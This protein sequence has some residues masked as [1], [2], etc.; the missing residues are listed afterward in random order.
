MLKK[1]MARHGAL[2]LGAGLLGASALAVGFASPALAAQSGGGSAPS[3][4]YNIYQGG[5]NTTY[6]MMQQLADVFNQAPGCDLASLTNTA[7][8]LDYGCPG[9]ND[10]GTT[11]S[12]PQSTTVTGTVTSG[13]KT[14]TAV[15]S[16]TGFVA[17]EGVS[18]AAGDIPA[19]TKIK[20]VT[21][22][23]IKISKPATGSA[24]GEN[25]SV[26][27]TPAVG[28]DG[29]TTFAQENPFNDLLIEEPAIG[30]SNGIQELEDQNAHAAG[31]SSHGSPIN[32]APLDVA[33]SSRAPNL[34]SPSSA[35]DDKGLN[36]V[37]Y[38]MDAVTWLHWTSVGNVATPSAA[39]SN[40][41]VANLT[42]IYMNQ[43]CTAGGQTFTT[44]NW[45]CFGGSVAPISVYMAQNGSG[46]ESTWASLLGLTG[47]FPFGGEDPN[48]VIFENETSSILANKDQANAIFFFSFG[49][50]E[51]IC[52]SNPTFCS[53]ASN[54][55]VALGQIAGIK[56]SKT[57]IANQLPGSPNAPF[58]GDRLLFNVYADGSNPDINISSPA[59]LNAVSEDGFLCKPSSSTDVDPNTGA[60]YRTEINSI[61]SAQGF[62]PLPLMVEDGQ[63]ATS[64]IYGT[65][66]AG[67]PNPAW[68]STGGLQGSAYNA[69]HEAVS[70][71]N[72]PTG[73]QDT[74]NSAISGTYSGVYFNGNTNTTKTA[75]ATDPIG[76]CLT[77]SSDGNSTN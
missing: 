73:D 3:L 16:T 9:L 59:S 33:R 20:S 22:S 40:L 41:S 75:S 54:S 69:S 51:T 5:S 7:Q 13:S 72:F 12:A 38:A 71:W 77:E 24:T 17:N 64:G 35:G 53:G 26:V 25:I 29:F 66:G 18:D 6:L 11:L 31:A 63:G 70:P 76:F 30:S 19:G 42:S 10:A 56:A 48:H 1:L 67:I 37:A 45:A 50:F 2:R 52:A 36:F 39:V 28:E 44:P 55:K 43:G 14:I 47:T 23:T 61:I 74:D 21:A 15:S 34:T 8:P 57:T 46:T 65:T 49:K 58:P 62:F 27:T 60:T 4:N 32:V 68:S